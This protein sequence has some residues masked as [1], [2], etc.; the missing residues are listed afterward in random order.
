LKKSYPDDPYITMTHAKILFYGLG[1]KAEA[2]ELLQNS[3]LSNRNEEFV[4]LMKKMDSEINAEE[5][6][7]ETTG[8]SND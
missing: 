7:E 2:L 5:I 4:S 6:T 8:E 3:N 1:K